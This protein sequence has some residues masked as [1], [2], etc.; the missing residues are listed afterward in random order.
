MPSFWLVTIPVYNE[1][2]FVGSWSITWCLAMKVGMGLRLTVPG[3]VRDA[4][5]SFDL[6]VGSAVRII[7]APKVVVLR[8]RTSK[9][10]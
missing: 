8:T 4:R 3:T 10:A 7:D 9:T 6:L 1:S 2:V 5:E